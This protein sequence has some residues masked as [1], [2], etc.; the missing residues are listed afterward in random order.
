[1][2]RKQAVFDPDKVD[3]LD[4]IRPARH[5]N[6]QADP[7]SEAAADAYGLRPNNTNYDFAAEVPEREY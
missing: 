6:G 5:C 2:G 4:M 7:R 3:G 1:M